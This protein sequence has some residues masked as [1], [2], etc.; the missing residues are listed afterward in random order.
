MTVSLCPGP[1]SKTSL[2]PVSLSGSDGSGLGRPG[3]TV[4]TYNTGSNSELFCYYDANSGVN[5]SPSVNP[6]ICPENAGE[7]VC[8]S[9]PPRRKRSETKLERVVRERQWKPVRNVRR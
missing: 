3:S 9:P 8:T 2:Q 5:S 6:T 4:C 7:K 1:V